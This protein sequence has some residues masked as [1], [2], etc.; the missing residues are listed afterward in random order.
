MTPG[1][2]SLIAE[3][4]AQTGR[5]P[6]QTVAATRPQADPQS[7]TLGHTSLRAG[8]SFGRVSTRPDVR[9]TDGATAGTGETVAIQ[10][11]ALV[12]NQNYEP[13]NVC[14][15]RRAFVLVLHGKADVLTEGEDPLIGAED[16]LYV[17]PSVIRLRHFVRRPHPRPRL[18][19]REVFQRDQERCQ[20]CGRRGGDLTLDHVLPKHRGGPHVWENLVTACRECNHKKGGRTPQEARMELL[21]QPA[22]PSTHPAVLFAPYLDRYR[23]WAQFVLGWGKA[24]AAALAGIDGAD[25]AS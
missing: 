2:G 8:A 13:L 10:R 14:S 7:G 12:L 21:K 24:P 1:A 22:R 6:R 20:Y 4:P 9:A 3:G 16:S 19:R 17:T 23:E 11:R 5:A 15:V 18:T 25:A